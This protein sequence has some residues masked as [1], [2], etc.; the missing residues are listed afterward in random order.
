M[1]LNGATTSQISL[2]LNLIANQVIY[3][4]AM[5]IVYKYGNDV[6]NY[7]VETNGKLALISLH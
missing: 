1:E 6:F 5:E 3:Q 7:F 4:D 2:V